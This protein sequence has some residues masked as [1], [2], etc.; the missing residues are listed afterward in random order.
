MSD[1]DF[2]AL[3]ADHGVNERGRRLIESVRNG[4][5]ARAVTGGRGNVTGRYPSLKMRRTIQYESRNCEFAFVISCEVDETIIEFWDQPCALSLEYQSKS[6][7]EGKPGRR[8]PVSHTPDFLVI[9]SEFVG[10]VECK[11]V[12]QL[13]K[14]SQKAPARYVGHAG[15]GWRCPPGE[16]AAARYGLGYRVWT[17]AGLTPAFVDNMRFL[18][19]EWGGSTRTFP[20]ADVERVIERVGAKPGITLE[21]LVHEIGDPDLV[22]WSIFRRRVHV[23]LAANFLSHSDR[24][25][26]FVD[27]AAAAAWSAAVA[28]VSDT[29]VT[30][31]DVLARSVLANYPQDALLVA[32]ERY[33]V[34]HAAIKADLP[35]RRLTGPKRA[36]HKRWL[37]AYRKAQRGCGIGLVGLC[38]KT[39]LRG[40]Y[41]ARFPPETYEVLEKV[42]AEEYEHRRGITATVAHAIAVGRCMGRG[43]PC[44]SYDGFLRFLERRDQERAVARRQGSKAAAALAPAFGPRDPAV[45][46]QGPMDVVHIDH[47]VLD[48]LV[49]V[50]VGSAATEERLWLTLATCAW[51]RCVV[52]YDLSFDPPAVAG[53]FTAMRDVLDRQ[54]RL[55]NQVVVDGGSEF[56]SVAFDQLCAACQIEK[57]KRP[58]SRPKFGSVVERVFGT[59][60][61]QFAHTLRGNTQLL[62]EPR[63]LSRDAAPA[64]DAIWRLSE[65]DLALRRFLFELYPRQPHSGLEGMTPEARFEQ[66][67]ATVGSG[68]RF[69]ESSDVRFLLWPPYRRGT[70]MVNSRKG[71]HVEH[72]DYWHVDMLA[73]ELAG[74]RVPVRVDPHDVTHVLAYLQGRWVLCRADCSAELAGYSRRQLRLASMVLHRRARDVGKRRMLRTRQLADMLKE[75]AETEQGLLQARRDEER[76]EVLKK[77]K[78]RLVGDSGSPVEDGPGSHETAWE[79]LDLDELGSGNL[80]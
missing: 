77:R 66:G 40:N 24:V 35:A 62:K 73:A 70:A 31:A 80:L 37:L 46:G 30:S 22:H 61:S 26:V 69:S 78:L 12:D 34:L 32:M 6:K 15:A 68:R 23:D 47:T 38:P 19:V 79:S 52:G 2:D 27:G 72:V 3:L 21:E 14:L 74:K 7:V 50:G 8:V 58:P 45:L 51:S 57:R 65:L 28:S 41:H 67:S 44:M 75:L 55:P 42:A 39:H 5:P 76:D 1:N 25:Q 36:T 54:K 71:I 43:I 13:V 49:R 20:T 59:T 33:R 11:L 4:P 53:L 16:A 64:Q 48:V 10:F 17:P 9:G 18:E 63:R 60:N 56:D 29:G